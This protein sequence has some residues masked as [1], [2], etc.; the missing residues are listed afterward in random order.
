MKPESMKSESMKPGS[1][2]NETGVKRADSIPRDVT[3]VGTRP[4]VARRA[5]LSK[6]LAF[7]ALSLVVLLLS[8]MPAGAHTGD[9]SYL[10]L[11]VTETTLS[12]RVEMPF[13]DLRQFLDLELRGE[14]QEILTELEANADQ[15]SAYAGSHFAIGSNG[16]A[17]PVTFTE[18]ERLDAEVTSDPEF[19]YAIVNF[20]TTPPVAQIPRMFDVTFDPF[21]DELPDERDALLLIGNDWAGGVLDNPEESLLRF[22]SNSRSQTV[23]L[24][25]ASWFKNFKAS[26]ALGLDHIK[27]GPDHILFVLVLLLPSVLIFS[28]G[29][30]PTASF[31]SSLWRVLKV[32]TMFTIAHTITFTLAGLDILP[33]PSPRLTE[34]VIAL[35]IAAAALHNLRPIAINREWVISFAFGLFHGMGFASLVSGLD[36]SRSTQLVS[37]LGRNV[38]IEI[39]QSLVVLAAFPALFLLRRTRFYQPFFVVG[40]VGLVIVSLGWM[41]ERLFDAPAIATGVVDRIFSFPRIYFVMVVLTVLAAV[42]NSIER[43]ADRLLPVADLAEPARAPEAV[44]VGH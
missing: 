39:G 33:L 5:A 3:L 4:V 32:V 12:G 18:V 42:A 11:D 10:Y 43:R 6:R 35:S 38:G 40:S 2:M 14:P 29:W 13:A 25:D 21:F 26:I 22:D 8:V 31:G 41:T 36:V 28:S 23:D 27:T 37:L 1:M 44:G 24:G 9:Q 34:T 15:L 17:W 19:G 30:K 20:V 7:V 16:E